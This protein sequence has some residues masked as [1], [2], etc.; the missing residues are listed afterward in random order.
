MTMTSMTYGVMPSREEWGA[1][2]DAM[3]AAGELRG[4]LYHIQLGRS[5]GD[6]VEGYRLGDGAWNCTGLFDAVSEIV[7]DTQG[8]AIRV[9]EDEEWEDVYQVFFPGDLPYV[10]IGPDEGELIA[11]ATKF[12]EDRDIPNVQRARE[13]LNFSA[14]YGRTGKCYERH[15]AAMD[16]VSS[17][18]ETMGFEW[19]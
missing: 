13:C 4:G 7:A 6:A 5:D 2:W 15:D 14:A 12:A 8:D 16:L 18:M 9:S 19:L 3:D 1:R 10:E 17:I 11:W